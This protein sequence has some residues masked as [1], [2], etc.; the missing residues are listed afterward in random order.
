MITYFTDTDCDINAQVAKK[1]GYKLISM[2]YSLFD[3]TVYP[4][5]DF[6]EFDD[7]TFYQTLREVSKDDLPTTSTL[8][9]ESY[10]EYFEPEFKKGNDIFYVHF[11]SKMTATFGYMKMALDELKQR[12]PD[13]KFYE[14]DTKGI[15]IASYIITCEIGDM[16][17]EGRSPEDILKWAETEVDKFAT[18]FYANDLKFF[19]KSGRVGGLAAIMGTIIGIR[20]IITMDGNGV[21]T[22]VGKVRGKENAINKLLSYVDEL[23]DNVKDHRIIIG[24]CDCM[25]DALKVK[26]GLEEKY[27]KLDNIEIVPVNPT[28]GSH[29]GPDTIGIS[30]HAIHR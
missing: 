24:H 4:Y 17:L 27:G 10:I 30:F 18:Y 9:K 26:E 6:D 12:Y 13:R 19:R 7:K 23:G 21:M 1:Y 20:P 11:S 22:N 2:P 3:K 29:C 16:I 15:T 25:G 8:T 14:V 5:I 28:A